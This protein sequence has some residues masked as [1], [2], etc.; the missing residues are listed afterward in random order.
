MLFYSNT[1]KTDLTKSELLESIS[2]RIVSKEDNNWKNHL[3]PKDDSS[4]ILRGTVTN[5]SFIVWITNSYLLGSAYP[6]CKG[7]ISELN[8]MRALNLTIRFNPIAEIFIIAF[9]ILVAYGL[10]TDLIIQENNA[11]NFLWKRCI[12]AIVIF[13]LINSVPIYIFYSGKSKLFKFVVEILL[14]KEKSTEQ[15][16]HRS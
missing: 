14:K 1:Y 8:E 7:E 10:I 9:N 2:R 5:E 11:F 3:F 16:T 12:V 6:I 13:F 4:Q 15:S